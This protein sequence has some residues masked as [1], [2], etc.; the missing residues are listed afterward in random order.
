MHVACA[1]RLLSAGGKHTPSFR[2]PLS[3]PHTDAMSRP[4]FTIQLKSELQ[5]YSHSKFI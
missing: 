5:K 4:Q 3:Q 1:E 2:R